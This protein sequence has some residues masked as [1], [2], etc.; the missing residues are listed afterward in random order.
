[1]VPSRFGTLDRGECVEIREQVGAEN[2]FLFGKTTEEIES[3]G[4]A[5]TALG[6]DAV[7]IPELPRCCT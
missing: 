1:M 7:S 6:L 3:L 2:F 4:M 5:A